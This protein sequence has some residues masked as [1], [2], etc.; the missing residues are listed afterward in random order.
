MESSINALEEIG[1]GQYLWSTMVVHSINYCSHL[2][3]SIGDE[4]H[5]KLLSPDKL[6]MAR[7]FDWVGREISV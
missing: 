6:T 1:L 7:L 3:W 2:Q 4:T 5:G